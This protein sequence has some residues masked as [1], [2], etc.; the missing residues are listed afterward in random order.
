MRTAWQPQPA[1]STPRLV[2]RMGDMHRA[3]TAAAGSRRSAVLSLV[4]A[5][6]PA[7]P[8]LQPPAHRLP[9]GRLP[10]ACRA[11]TCPL[12]DVRQREAAEAL[13]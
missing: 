10:T 11:A 6:A 1:W 12:P 3:T 7:A 2:V 5:E 4:G 9:C 13:C 8:A